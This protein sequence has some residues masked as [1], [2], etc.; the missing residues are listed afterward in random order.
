MNN[1]NEQILKITVKYDDA[2]RN[3]A[4]YRTSIEN[5]KKE[6]AE[7][8]K[9][10]KDK[11]IS[12][13]EY[14]AK[15]V[16]TEKKMLEARDV[17][18]TLTKEVRNQIKIEKQQTGSL[19]QLRAQLSNLTAEYDSL[20]EVERKAGRG[21]ELKI[22]INGITDSLKEAEGETQR[23][24]R[25]VGSYEEAIKNALGMNNSFADSLLHMADNAKSGSGLFS[26]LKTEAS[27]FGNTL[28]SLL[29][30]KVFLG[31]AG[32]A[33]AGVVFKWWYDYN[34]GLVEATKLTRQFTDKS[35]DDLKAYR[36]EVQA[37]ADYYGKD[38]KEV[39]V[40]ANTISKQFGITSEKALQIVKDGFIAGADANGEFLDSL[41]EYPAYFKEAGIS[42]DPIENAQEKPEKA[43]ERLDSGSFCNRRI[44]RNFAEI[45]IGIRLLH[46]F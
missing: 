2:I 36:S 10:L 42:A 24:Y 40:S 30:N 31:I 26:N 41:K 27:A 32:I 8:K 44:F 38:F 39:L 15:I 46:K 33:G 35:G 16:E 6:E 20:S 11:K 21:Q 23:F 25:S 4:K 18:Q 37:L 13:E 14:N 12:Q 1:E 22:K 29:K 7:Y 19:K 5:L 34:K 28:T 17:V 43:P 45:R 3:I 9:A